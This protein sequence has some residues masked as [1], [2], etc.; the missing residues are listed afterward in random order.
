MRKN[1][2]NINLQGLGENLKDL[3]VG[4]NSLCICH[5]FRQQNEQENSLSKE[6]LYMPAGNI[7]YSIKKMASHK[8]EDLQ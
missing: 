5:I 8:K 7:I 3:V 6:G 4:F 1:I 2:S